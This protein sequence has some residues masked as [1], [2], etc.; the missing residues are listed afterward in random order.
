[1]RKSLSIYSD[2][3]SFA[4]VTLH[5][6]MDEKLQQTTEISNQYSKDLLEH[7]Y[8]SIISNNQSR[9]DNINNEIY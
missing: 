9:F 5:R 1:M 6:G 7:D 8:R 4:Y 3:N 2:G